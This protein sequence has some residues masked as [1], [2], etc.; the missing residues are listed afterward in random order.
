MLFNRI[1]PRCGQKQ[2]KYKEFTYGNNQN[3]VFNMKKIVLVMLGLV[4]ISMFLVGCAQEAEE[5]V[6]VVDEQGNIVGE[7]FRSTPGKYKLSQKL[8]PKEVLKPKLLILKEIM[9]WPD[10]SCESDANCFG[11]AKCF[12][13]VCEKPGCIGPTGDEFEVGMAGIGKTQ[14]TGMVSVCEYE[15]CPS[16]YWQISGGGGKCCATWTECNSD[17]D[18]DS[19]L[20]TSHEG[21]GKFCS[22]CY[23]DAKADEWGLPYLKCHEGKTCVNF[24]CQ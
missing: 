10:N 13:G 22:A 18:C 3:E 19:N 6:D 20:C 1:R 8:P 9:T 24:H 16:G 7:A 11:C 2:Y 4:V 14:I 23:S 21:V 17:S 15:S 12:N 5:K